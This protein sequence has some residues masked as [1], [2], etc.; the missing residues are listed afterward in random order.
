MQY[1]HQDLHRELT[2]LPGVYKELFLETQSSIGLQIVNGR[3][4]PV[5]RSESSGSSLLL[6]NV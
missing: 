2:L 6:T 4:E 5:S 1:S 3:T